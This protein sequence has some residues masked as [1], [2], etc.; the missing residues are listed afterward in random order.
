MK[1]KVRDIVSR[2]EEYDEIVIV[3]PDGNRE[4]PNT[5]LRV[6][7]HGGCI[8]KIPIGQG[9]Y[10]LV[11]KYKPTKADKYPYTYAKYLSKGFTDG[12]GNQIVNTGI[13]KL[14][15]EF[16]EYL[17]DGVEL[18]DYFVN[19]F[20]EADSSLKEKYIVDSNYLKLALTASYNKM[21]NDGDDPG[22][23]K[24]Q[25][26]IAKNQIKSMPGESLLVTDIEY[27]MRLSDNRPKKKSGKN[28]HHGKADFVVFDG[29]SI[30]LVELKYNNKSME[31]GSE[32]SL[33]E[34]MLDFYDVITFSPEDIIKECIRR[35]KVMAKHGVICDDWNNYIRKFEEKA[36]KN[37]YKDMI[38]CGFVF[39]NFDASEED[40]IKS[41]KNQLFDEAPCKD[42]R[43]FISSLNL[44][45][46][47]YKNIDVKYQYIKVGEEISGMKK[48][49]LET[50]IRDVIY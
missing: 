7:A 29:E 14:E 30:G 43:K 20:C 19:T 42:T 44:K 12:H 8:G 33:Y 15:K 5:K 2:L 18:Q 32:N 26:R 21:R 6:Y 49:V 3:G 35:I 39:A 34:H 25:T 4:N 1:S 9:D 50:S 40:S 22:E 27:K 13:D 23:R 37:A 45:D 11:G 38:W 31:Q 46:D 28:K 24:I 48:M 36:E 16:S 41:V 17:V 47:K 10:E